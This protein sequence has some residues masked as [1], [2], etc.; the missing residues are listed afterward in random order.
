MM[1]GAGAGGGSGGG[2]PLAGLMNNPELMNMAQQF[3]QDPK[4][5]ETLKNLKK[6]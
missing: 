2:N 5:Q 4:M 1:G 6:K 3:S